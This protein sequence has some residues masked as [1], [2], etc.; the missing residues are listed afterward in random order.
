MLSWESPTSSLR[1]FRLTCSYFCNAELWLIVLLAPLVDTTSNDHYRLILAVYT[2]QLGL[3]AGTWLATPP[4]PLQRSAT[5]ATKVA[6]WT[7]CAQTHGHRSSQCYNIDM[8]GTL[9]IDGRIV[10]ASRR[11][12]AQCTNFMLGTCCKVGQL[13]LETGL[14]G[15]YTSCY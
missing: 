10:T 11:R 1:P 5:H 2:R 8:N 15:F 6:I 14:P 7:G 9:T 13:L 4:P 12:A 3:L